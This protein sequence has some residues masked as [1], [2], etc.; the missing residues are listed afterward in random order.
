M[1]VVDVNTLESVNALDFLK[2]ELLELVLTGD[3]ENVV[4]IDV[5]VAQAL[6]SLNVI[7]LSDKDVSSEKY[8]MLVLFSVL[9]G[10]INDSL[11]LLDLTVADL[12]ADT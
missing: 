12:S 6:C 5:S 9:I 8:G 11:T 1:L 7:T 3:A 2:Q 10:D 4:R